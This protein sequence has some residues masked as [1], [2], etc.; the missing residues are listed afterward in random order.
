MCMYDVCVCVVFYMDLVWCVG[1]VCGVGY[2]VWMVY[3]VG[4]V[5]LLCVVYVL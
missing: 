1:V 2:V 4:Y 3:V 5:C